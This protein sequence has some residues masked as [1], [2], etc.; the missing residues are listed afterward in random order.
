MLSLWPD[1]ALSI[2]M[3]IYLT[4]LWERRIERELDACLNFSAY[5][6]RYLFKDNGF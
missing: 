6:L 3:L 4:W 1:T 5:L 2:D